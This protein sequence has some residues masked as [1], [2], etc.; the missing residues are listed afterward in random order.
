V[1]RAR[2]HLSLVVDEVLAEAKTASR[3]RAGEVAA[4]KVAEA[5]PRTEVARGL[6]AL[7]SELRTDSGSI[8]YADITR[9]S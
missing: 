9:T 6:R 3:R 5:Q 2:Q 1:S 8:T 7:A 4:I